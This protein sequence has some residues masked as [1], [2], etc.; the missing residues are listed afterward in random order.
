MVRSLSDLDV[1]LSATPSA[2]LCTPKYLRNSLSQ[3]A[4]FRQLQLQLPRMFLSASAS[5]VLKKVMG[6]NCAF[7]SEHLSCIKYY[8]R[9]RRV[10]LELHAF[11]QTRY[12]EDGIPELLPC[13][14]H[15]FKSLRLR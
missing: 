11:K 13:T 3:L 10:N 7:Y 6:V 15:L 4:Y 1:T 14:L 12:Y 8:D 5:A 9:R 2:M